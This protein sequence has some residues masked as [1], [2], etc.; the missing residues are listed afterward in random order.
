MWPQSLRLQRSQPRIWGVRVSLNARFARLSGSLLGQIARWE[1]GRG[2]L[3]K[4]FSEAFATIRGPLFRRANGFVR[5]L[6]QTREH[7]FAA[8]RAFQVTS[9]CAKDVAFGFYHEQALVS[10]VIT[11]VL[12]SDRQPLDIELAH[13]A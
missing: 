7:L 13:C 9:R 11:G 4:T 8:S 2:F 10:G 1:R 3:C 12:L 6:I 5:V